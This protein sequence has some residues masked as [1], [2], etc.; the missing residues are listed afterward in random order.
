[1]MKLFIKVSKSCKIM[2]VLINLK[3]NRI[4][5]RKMA[6]TKHKEQVSTRKK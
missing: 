1:M 6:I 4:V 2:T 5:T 3:L